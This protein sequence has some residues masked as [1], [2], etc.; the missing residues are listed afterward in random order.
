M[1]GAQ[2]HR[3]RT[4]QKNRL[5][6]FAGSIAAA[7]SLSIMGSGFSGNDGSATG[8]TSLLCGFQFTGP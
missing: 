4:A 8:V 5:S 2:A 6:L 7:I 3:D 1:H